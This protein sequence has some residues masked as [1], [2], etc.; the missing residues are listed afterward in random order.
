MLYTILAHYILIMF[1]KVELSQV[2]FTYKAF[3]G[4]QKIFWYMQFNRQN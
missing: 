4:I 1:L 2:L 3:F